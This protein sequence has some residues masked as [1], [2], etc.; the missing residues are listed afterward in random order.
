M[1]TFPV[2]QGVEVFMAPPEGYVVDFENPQQHT[3]LVSYILAG[4]GMVM[5][6]IFFIQY[7]Y[8]KLWLMQVLD[9]ETVLLIL[10]WVTGVVQNGVLLCTCIPLAYVVILML[11][12]GFVLTCLKLPGLSRLWA[13]THGR[14]PLTN[15]ISSTR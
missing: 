2:V 14:C 13:S 9:I 4:V 7:L 3:A 12:R 6:M 11:C 15:T 1:A 10:A 5:A 8:V